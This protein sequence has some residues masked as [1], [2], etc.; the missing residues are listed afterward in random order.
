MDVCEI[1]SVNGEDIGDLTETI[2]YIT[3]TEVKLIQINGDKELNEQISTL[4]NKPIDANTYYN[5]PKT[6]LKM[7]KEWQTITWQYNQEGGYKENNAVKFGSVIING[8]KKK[9]II[10]SQKITRPNGSSWGTTKTTYYVENIGYYMTKIGNQ[11]L[12]ILDSV[13]YDNS[14]ETSKSYILESITHENYNID[15]PVGANTSKQVSA[16]KSAFTDE[17]LRDMSIVRISEPLNM[18]LISTELGIDKKLLT[19]WNPDYDLFVCNTYPTP[20]YSLR[21]PK[22]KVDAFLS[23]KDFLAKKSRRIF[24]KKI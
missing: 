3:D 23:K 22:N 21:I 1:S 18:D 11:V 6:L 19:R 16:K 5:P 2:V 8:E 14:V 17:E 12:E 15:K 4:L 10:V 7:P 9:A 20:Y 13:S 24:G